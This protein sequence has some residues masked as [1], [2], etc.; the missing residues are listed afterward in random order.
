MKTAPQHVRAGQEVFSR[1]ITSAG[2]E[3]VE[4][5]KFLKENYFLRFKKVEEPKQKRDGR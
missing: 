5:K 4:E 1:E 3:Q 2:F